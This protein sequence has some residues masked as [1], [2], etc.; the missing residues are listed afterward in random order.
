MVDG[1]LRLAA[2]DAQAGVGQAVAELPTHEGRRSDFRDAGG[3][4]DTRGS[5]ILPL[6]VHCDVA[7]RSRDRRR[8]CETSVTA[9]PP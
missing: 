1:S 9:A 3:L 7:H 2:F 6:P 8:P 4:K 5:A